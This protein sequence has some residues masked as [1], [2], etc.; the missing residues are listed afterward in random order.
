MKVLRADVVLCLAALI[1]LATST[2]SNRTRGDEQTNATKYEHDEPAHE[3]TVKPHLEVLKDFIYKYILPMIVGI[4]L[5]G[6]SLTIIILSK[7][8]ELN[9][10][11]DSSRTFRENLRLQLAKRSSSSSKSTVVAA[12]TTTP[13]A[14]NVDAHSPAA[15]AVTTSAL[16][17]ATAAT[18]TTA[19]AAVGMA[20]SVAT[21]HRKSAALAASNNNNTS[22]KQKKSVYNTQFSSTNYFIFSLAV[23]DLIYNVVLAL[24]WI[25]KNDLMNILDRDYLC[26]SSV[27]VTYIC[28]FLSAAFTTLFTFQVHIF[29]VQNKIP[30]QTVAVSENN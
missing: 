6:N 11:Y 16:S 3:Q 14:A 25:T 2:V 28:S 13:P 7:E 22:R 12:A 17:A 23:S 15:A 18:V 4:G 30:I 26:Q 10:L 5:V 29:S 20:D 24:V 1:S 8:H 21:Y 19:A 9:A 27:A